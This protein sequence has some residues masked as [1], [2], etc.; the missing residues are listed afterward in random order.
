MR[1]ELSS[2][3][4]SLVQQVPAIRI[5]LIAHG[6][7][8]DFRSSYVV[9]TIDLTSDVDQ[10]VRYV[11]DVPQT[12]GGDSPEVYAV[13]NCVYVYFF[14]EK[15]RAIKPRPYN[16]LRVAIGRFYLKC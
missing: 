10:L 7:Y 12:G 15:V 6:D 1:C 14:W 2:M 9:K 13:I 5:G 8:C 3:V 4:R 11:K 16:Q